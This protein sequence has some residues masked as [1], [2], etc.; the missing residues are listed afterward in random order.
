MSF[1]REVKI[2]GYREVYVKRDAFGLISISAAEGRGGYG[3]SFG[4]SMW[5]GEVM[6]LRATLK[7]ALKALE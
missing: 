4:L 5:P 2:R 3:R 1:R 7:A 6:A